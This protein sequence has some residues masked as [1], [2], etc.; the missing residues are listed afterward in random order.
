MTPQTHWLPAAELAVQSASI[1]HIMAIAREFASLPVNDRPLYSFCSRTLLRELLDDSKKI[2][3]NMD[4]WSVIKCDHDAYNAM[5]KKKR[6]IDSMC[7]SVLFF[8]ASGAPRHGLPT[9]AEFAEEAFRDAFPT[10]DVGKL[11]LEIIQK[12]TSQNREY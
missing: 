7:Y 5:A 1:E 12:H 9:I 3:L 8:L 4:I 11:I 10:K 2:T 6:P